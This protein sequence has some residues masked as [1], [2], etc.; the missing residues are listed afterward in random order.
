MTA[1][2]RLRLNTVYQYGLQTLRL[3]RSGSQL[4]GTKLVHYI[5]DHLH[6]NYKRLFSEMCGVAIK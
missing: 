3:V 5:S 1:G 4:R 2:V 6:I